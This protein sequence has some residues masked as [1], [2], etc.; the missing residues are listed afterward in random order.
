MSKPISKI[1][2]VLEYWVT[3]TPSVIDFTVEN[4]LSAIKYESTYDFVFRFL[5][6]K[7]G[8]ELL[9]SRMYLCP[10]NHKAYFSNLDEELDLLDLPACHICGQEICNDLDH[11]FLIFN[12]TEDFKEDAKKKY[13]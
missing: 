11:S 9:V 12:F 4:V 3:L 8:F 10:E 13:T 5:M 6:S 1:N 2:A 7:N